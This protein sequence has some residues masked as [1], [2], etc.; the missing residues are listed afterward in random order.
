MSVKSDPIFKLGSE[1]LQLEKI[2]SKL[3]PQ[4]LEIWGTKLKP[5]PREPWMKIEISKLGPEVL[6]KKE[7]INTG[8]VTS[9]E[10]ELD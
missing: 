9:Y 1:V 6:L 5:T 2:V 10:C 8:C 4:S 7:P 3:K